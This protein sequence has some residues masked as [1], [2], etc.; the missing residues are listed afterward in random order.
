M[1]E[2]AKDFNIK[3]DSDNEDIRSLKHLLRFGLEG[4]A[5]YAYHALELGE[6]DETVTNFFI[7]HWLLLQ[8]TL[9]L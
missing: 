3:K 6:S 8:M 7:K 5:A 9:L 4:L 2:K 1:I